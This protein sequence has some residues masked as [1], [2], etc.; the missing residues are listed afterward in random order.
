M[1]QV[2]IQLVM[3]AQGEMSL[4]YLADLGRGPPPREDRQ[5]AGLC[6]GRGGQG[7]PGV[8]GQPHGGQAAAVGRRGWGHDLPTKAPGAGFGGKG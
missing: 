3:D 8:A 6:C 5:A 7:R 2:L 1:D 4:E